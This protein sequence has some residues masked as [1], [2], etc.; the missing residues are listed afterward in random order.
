MFCTSGANIDFSSV[1]PAI[2]SIVI[3]EISSSGPHTSSLI[4]ST[5]ISSSS[6]GPPSRT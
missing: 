3:R 6:I 2:T 4:V 5:I 1:D